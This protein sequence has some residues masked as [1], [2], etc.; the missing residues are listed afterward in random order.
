[1]NN[2]NNL[3]PPVIRDGINEDETESIRQIE[4]SM[5]QVSTT[6]K[7]KGSIV[8]NKDVVKLLRIVHTH[9]TLKYNLKVKFHAA[10]I[11]FLLCFH[12]QSRGRLYFAMRFMF[13]DACECYFVIESAFRSHKTYLSLIQFKIQIFFSYRAS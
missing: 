7:T 5:D 3:L 8:S 9:G 4:E 1:M 12:G 11:A 13:C 2:W 6:F 10:L